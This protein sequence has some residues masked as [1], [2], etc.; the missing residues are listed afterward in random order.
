MKKEPKY[1]IKFPSWFGYDSYLNVKK[2]DGTLTL[3]H[4]VQDGYWENQFTQTQIDILQR[5]EDMTGLD[6]NMF[7]V[8]VPDDELED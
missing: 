3:D 8:K 4:K 1:Y 6:L 5:S 2:C 7:K